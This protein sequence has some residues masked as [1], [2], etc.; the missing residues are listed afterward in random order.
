MFQL[1]AAA[2]FV[3]LKIFCH[4]FQCRKKKNLYL[5]LVAADIWYV[6]PEASPLY[7]V[8]LTWICLLQTKQSHFQGKVNAWWHKP[9][10][11]GPTQWNLNSGIWD[12]PT[13]CVCFSCISNLTYGEGAD[14]VIQWEESSILPS[15]AAVPEQRWSNYNTPRLLRLHPW[16]FIDCNP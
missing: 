8:N 13:D 5:I 10:A 2:D 12:K 6:F 1:P 11:L 16:S 3:L 14:E 9:T 7:L 15:S 4:H